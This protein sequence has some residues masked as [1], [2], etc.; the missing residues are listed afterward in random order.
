MNVSEIISEL[1][2]LF[3]DAHCEL[4]YR[5]PF[6]LTIAVVLSAQTTDIAV[7]KVTAKLF[8]KYD[9]AAK[10]ADANLDDVETIIKKIGLYHN[11]ALNIIALSKQLID[12]FDGVVPNTME[13]LVTLKGVGR[14]T[15]N[16]ILGE[17]YNI[18]ALAVDTHVERVA[19]RLGLVK[20]DA[21]VEEVERTL[22]KKIPIEYWIKCHHLLIFFGRYLCQA[23]KPLCGDCPFVSICRFKKTAKKKSTL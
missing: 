8:E 10:L 1:E 22:K 7:N 3:P 20:S 13:E 4:N 12:D 16:V 11:K 21:K 17:C 5:S 23:R 18:P 19:K 2:H 14:K 15:A 9:T 6:E